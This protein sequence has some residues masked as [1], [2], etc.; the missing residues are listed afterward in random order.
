MAFDFGRAVLD[1]AAEILNSLRKGKTF[2]SG[3]SANS[4]LAFLD[5]T[6][7][8]FGT[9]SWLYYMQLLTG[10][11]NTFYYRYDCLNYST[12]FRCLFA[13]NVLQKDKLDA[14]F[15]FVSSGLTEL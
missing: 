2:I 14:N 15:I 1:R 3:P 10:K 9:C 5:L 12:S 11:S 6:R 8:D 4:A 7:F 13:D